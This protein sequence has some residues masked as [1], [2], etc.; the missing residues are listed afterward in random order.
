MRAHVRA[1]RVAAVRRRARGGSGL[2]AR[3]GLRDEGRPERVCRSRVPSRRTRR[4]RQRTGGG[5]A[6]SPGRR[7]RRAASPERRTPAGPA[8]ARPP[9]ET[10]PASGRSKPAIRRRNVVLPQPDGP[11]SARISPRGDVERHV[12]DGDDVAEPFRQS[13]DGNRRLILRCPPW[14][15]RGTTP[16]QEL[17]LVREYLWRPRRNGLTSSFPAWSRA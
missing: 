10:V 14:D 4:C 9:R 7:R 15:R 13:R 5:R 8:T 17:H 1:R 6:R 12:V 3:S 2:T 11:S 16:P